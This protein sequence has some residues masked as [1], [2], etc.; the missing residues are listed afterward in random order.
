MLTDP[1]KGV[2]CA[3]LFLEDHPKRDGFMI[4]LLQYSQAICVGTYVD[5]LCSFK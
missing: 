1:N 2:E 3:S 4:A 5:Y